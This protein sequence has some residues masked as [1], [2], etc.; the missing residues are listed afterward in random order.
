MPSTLNGFGLRPVNHPSG[1]TRLGT[2]TIGSG[3]A[4][5]IWENSPVR[6][7]PGGTINI[8]GT[9][10]G[11]SDFI[12]VLHHVEYFDA[13]GIPQK[14]NRWLASTPTAT[15]TVITAFVTDGPF[16]TYEIQCDGT[17]AQTVIGE[18][19]NFTSVRNGG[20]QVG[21]SQATISNQ[22]VGI[23]TQ[24]QLRIIGVSGYPDNALSDAYPTVLV[25]VAQHQFVGNAVSV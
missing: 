24:G 3:Y 23:G 22:L 15:N 14:R 16:Q 10:A 2:Y 1:V 5:T 13:D 12:G 21:I 6:I 9:V 20:T 4:T 8:V 17:L 19:A 25:Q 7:S 18:Q 11:T